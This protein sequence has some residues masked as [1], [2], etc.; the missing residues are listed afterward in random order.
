MAVA[1]ILGASGGIGGALEARLRQTR[2]DL[3]VVGLSRKTTLAFDVGKEETVEQAAAYCSSLG[4]LELV[5]N[6]TGILSTQTAGPEK[7]WR[8]IDP[9]EMMAVFQVNAI[10]PALVMK[11]FLPKLSREGRAVFAN[12]S[13]RVGS[14]GDNHLGGWYS[15]RASKAALNQLV[16]T[17]SVELQRRNP[18]AICVALHPGTVATN[19]SEGF[20]ATGLEV[21]DPA[22][23]AARILKVIEGLQPEQTGGFYDHHG[24]VIP[25]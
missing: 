22:T 17:A 20:Q 21:Q 7:S 24:K 1:V 5:V 3:A 19:L 12:L 16:H 2:P 10:G 25:W 14:I 8:S 11:H 6:A 23:A 15:Y 4:P 9:A 13:A 18:Q